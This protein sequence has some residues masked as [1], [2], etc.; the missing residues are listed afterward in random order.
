M[1]RIISLLL[2]HFFI[3][4]VSA[5]QQ[6]H[7]HHI[8]IENGDAILIGVYDVGSQKYT[9][10]ILI[11]GGQSTPNK[12][13]LPYIKKMIGT[14]PESL[15][16]NYI[17]LTHYHSDHYNGLLAIKNGRLTA[18]SII[19]P[20]G[21]II[22]TVF[23]HSA[24]IGSVPDKLIVNDKWLRACSTA[25]HHT[26]N[27]F[28]S[29]RSKIFIRFDRSPQTSIGR[30]INIGRIGSADVEL[31]C[32]AGWGNTLSSNNEIEPNP[33]P[34][35]DNGNNFTL[36]FILSYG[37]F[38]YFIA[39]DMGGDNGDK[40][41][42]QE[43]F[44]TKY[45]EERFPSAL[46]ISGDSTAKGHMCGFKA[47]HHGSKHSNT[48]N[49]MESMHP[50]IVITSAGKNKI[51]KLPHTDYLNRLARVEPLSISLALPAGFSNQGFYFTNLNNFTNVP[52]KSTANDLFDNVSGL[53]YDFGNKT[54]GI[55]AS[56]LIK[57]TNDGNTISDKSEFE[58]GRVDITKPAPY[59]RLALFSCH[60]KQ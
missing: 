29:G 32:I 14:D 31:E 4:V 51:W 17:G 55:K 50:S 34:N 57:V 58:V 3:L 2:I 21:Y 47:S 7:I 1:K 23:N 22:N 27:P 16:F 60:K 59:Q 28:I 52:S 18:D 6:L 25:A 24:D 54:S 37:E 45:F 43:E 40:Y 42:D 46:S 19:D 8:N 9:S 36:A 56:Y 48:S 12:M 33:L 13:L 26:P 10:K 30:K 20:G 44:V 35:K 15:H 38:R 41:I 53:N 11:D 39:G 5:Q 49:F